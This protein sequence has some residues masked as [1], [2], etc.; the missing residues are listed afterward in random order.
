MIFWQRFQVKDIEVSLGN[1]PLINSRQQLI[2]N[3]MI[4][5]TNVYDDNSIRTQFK[6]VMI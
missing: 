3:E 1:L 5:S 6:K 4:T 2:F